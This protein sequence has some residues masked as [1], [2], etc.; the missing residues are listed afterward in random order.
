MPDDSPND[1][2]HAELSFE[3]WRLFRIL[4]EFVDGFDIMG[5]L[6]PCV[7]VFGSARTKPDDPVYQ[8]AVRCGRLVCE[9]G[10][11]VITGGGPGIMEA[12]N[13]GA[14]EV[15]DT[16]GGIS[17][18]LNI[19]L[20]FEQAPNPYQ[21]HP[22]NFRYFFIRKVMFVKYA[23]GFILFPG[24]FGTLDELFETLTL[25]QTEKITRFP[26][27]LVG[28]DF[29]GGLTEWMT[30]TMRDQYQT[31]S[32]GDEELFLLTDS[33]DEAVQHIKNHFDREAWGHQSR[34]IIPGPPPGEG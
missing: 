6:G 8:Q 34:R 13:K 22:L 32:P 1:S 20:P 23:C 30:K 24:G 4:S 16:C 25:V 19:D 17:V 5:G 14:Y 3:S 10:F 26:V 15:K 28:K 27:A 29:W 12:A 21:T 2:R 18:G 9:A 7:T 31:I 11:G 33:E